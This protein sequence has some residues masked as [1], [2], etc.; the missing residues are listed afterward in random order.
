MAVVP[1]VGRP[2]GPI[3]SPFPPGYRAAGVL[4]HLTSL[5]SPY[6]IGDLGLPAFSWID[7]LAEAKQSWW[8]I[9]PLS[10]TGYGYSPFEPLSTFSLNP[11][12]VSPE[13]LIEDGL[14]QTSDCSGGV[15]P[16]AAVDYEQ[17]VPFKS[18]LLDRA[19]QNY[20]EGARG[21]LRP[22]FEAFC[23]EQAGWLDDYALFCAL[24]QKH[25]GAKFLDWPAPELHREPAAMRLAR[26]ELAEQ[27]DRLRFEQFLLER[28]AKALKSHAL[29]RGVR[30][31]GDLPFF[32]ALDS[33]EVWARPELF[34]LDR[35]CLPRFLSGVPP[36]Y[37]SR[38]GQL[39]GTPLYDWE[40]HRHSGFEWWIGRIRSL[41]DYVDLIRLDHFRAFAAAWHVPA[42]E[43]TAERGEWLSGPG[44]AFFEAAQQSLGA[45]PLVAE[46]LGLL[47][48][49]VY[50]LR[51][52]FRLPGMRVLQFAF[53]GDPNNP[54]L[55]QNYVANTVVYT[56]THDNDTIRG[57]FESLPADARRTVWKCLAR[58]GGDSGDSG[59]TTWELIR[60]AFSSPAALAM[61]PLQDIL[62]L[63]ASARM[64]V[65]GGTS[66]NWRWRSTE[67]M[68]LQGPEFRRLL[69][70][71]EQSGR[72]RDPI[73]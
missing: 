48:P 23:R 19:W 57:W 68:M 21:D 50:E 43:K 20:R 38:T 12:L 16:A 6:G 3:G 44:A 60:L 31:I 53:D 28:Q 39:W 33:C 30:L 41:L 64:N 8:Q 73:A 22:A 59:E 55:P 2:S 71:T 47:T 1:D 5:P 4:L 58:P 26:Q 29:Q 42:G 17:V 27:L 32:V 10:A 56:G 61:V 49:D 66:G 67:Q 36:D 24:K 52:R 34:L 70:L 25:G 51:D 15:F 46:D 54:F 62:N 14:L 13:R 18:R 65:P 63:D 11:A 9:L 37:F 69:E 7:R 72:A 45:L 35:E 40:S